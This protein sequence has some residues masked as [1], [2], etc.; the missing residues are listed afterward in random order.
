MCYT[1]KIVLYCIVFTN[2]KADVIK[3]RGH[4]S[5]DKAILGL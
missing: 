2:S 5:T 3:T 1:K 4:Q